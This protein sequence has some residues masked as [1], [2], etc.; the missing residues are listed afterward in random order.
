MYKTRNDLTGKKFGRLTVIKYEYTTKH[1][2]AV[3]SCSCLCG[4]IANIIGSSLMNGRTKSCGCLANE[5]TSKRLKVHGMTESGE[6]E[7]WCNMKARCYNPNIKQYKDWG[8]RGITVCQEWL[9]SFEQFYVDMGPRPSSEYSIDRI[10][11]DGNYCKENCR[12]ATRREQGN[13]TRSN[14]LIPYGGK[15][16]NLTDWSIELKIKY[17]TLAGR[18]GKGWTIEEAFTRSVIK[19][20]RIYKTKLTN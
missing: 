11:N 7:T 12:W 20:K 1:K 13:N 2:K 16:Q 5:M 8:G 15:T 19:R 10:D 3:W 6:F 17:S 9:D 4:N 14:L 18:I